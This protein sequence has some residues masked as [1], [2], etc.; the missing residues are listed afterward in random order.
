MELKTL[1]L[2]TNNPG[3]VEE[4]KALLERPGLRLIIPAEI[5][6]I[7]DV[8]EDGKDYVENASLKARAFAQASKLISLA[9]DSGLEVDLLDGQPGIHSHRFAP[10]ANA[11]DGDRRQYLLEKLKGNPRPWLARF[12]ATIALAHPDGKLRIAHGECPGE[13]IP[14]ERG[15]NG[16]GYDPIFLLPEKGKTMAELSL[17]EKNHLSHRAKAIMNAREHLQEMMGI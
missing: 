6:L 14:D 7:L 2:A 3:K 8:R 10:W 13:I 12:H 17:E 4:M 1:L 11:S 5:G 16:F 9:D 15:T